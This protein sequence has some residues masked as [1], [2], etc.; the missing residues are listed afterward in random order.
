M[1]K[2]NNKMQVDIENLFKQNVND[3]LSI[4]E[5]YIKLEEVG[6]KI[7]QV[8]YIDNTLVKKIKKEYEKLKKIILDE[9]IQVKITNDIETINSQIQ[10]F[11]SQLET[12]TNTVNELNINSFG[13]KYNIN[14]SENDVLIQNAFNYCSDNKI[15]LI[16]SDN[17]IV[18]KTI[19]LKNGLYIKGNSSTITDTSTPRIVFEPKNSDTKLFTS[20]NI[21]FT[22]V[23]CDLLF[24]TNKT[25]FWIYNKKLDCFGDLKFEN[26]LLDRIIVGGFNNIFNSCSFGSVTRIQNCKTY[27]LYTS[28]FNSCSFSD[29]FINDNYFN[30]GKPVNNENKGFYPELFKNIKNVGLIKFTGNW[31]EFVKNFLIKGETITISNNIFDYIYQGETGIGTVCGNNTFSHFNTSE[32]VNNF[33]KSKIEN[34]VDEITNGVTLFD[35]KNYGAIIANNIFARYFIDDNTKLFNISGDSN[36]SL[37][38]VNIFNNTFYDNP[39][40]LSLERF[41]L[42]AHND[43]INNSISNNNK[44]DIPYDIAETPPYDKL[45][46]GMKFKINNK[47]LNVIY[48]NYYK[49]IQI[50]DNLMNDYNFKDENNLINKPINKWSWVNSDWSDENGNIVITPSTSNSWINCYLDLDVNSCKYIM[51]DKNNINLVP[52]IKIEGQYNENNATKNITDSKI[53]NVE[54]V[55]TFKIWIKCRVNDDKKDIPIKFNYPKLIK[56]IS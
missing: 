9:N 28:I 11:N 53:L 27:N 46:Q 41:N 18:G 40:S 52:E 14:S 45:V 35:I 10:T 31:V 32:I 4:K 8:K 30:G 23:I 7:T 16:I 48:S 39:F 1:S 36:K 17:L 29:I 38:G 2:E 55:D 33:K 12:V 37:K 15:R 44:I 6:E 3:L 13:V 5:L 25:N 49:H 56:Y 21:S 47:D 22:G 50:V 26:S 34:I 42:L 19:T 20:N 51:F 24:H 54:N 43:N